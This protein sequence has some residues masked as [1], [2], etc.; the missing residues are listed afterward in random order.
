MSFSNSNDSI[1]LVPPP[2]GSNLYDHLVPSLPPSEVAN[3]NSRPSSATTTS[4]LVLHRKIPFLFEPLKRAPTVGP[5]APS[6]HS[7][8]RHSGLHSPIRVTSV[9]T[10]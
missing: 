6:S 7:Q 8:C 2:S 10:S 5:V 1:T 3:A 9:T 4:G